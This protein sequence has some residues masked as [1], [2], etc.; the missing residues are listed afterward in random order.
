MAP[1]LR[2]VGPDETTIDR[3]L[4]HWHI[5]C[6]TGLLS[7]PFA[8]PVF[9]IVTHGI[10]GHCHGEFCVSFFSLDLPVIVATTLAADHS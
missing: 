1:P 2:G 3:A 7:A 4:F 9:T 10:F 5:S 6:I 8:A